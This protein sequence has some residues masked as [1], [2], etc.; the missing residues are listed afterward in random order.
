MSKR[1]KAI[2]SRGRAALGLLG[3][4]VAVSAR[5]QVSSLVTP[6]HPLTWPRTSAEVAAANRMPRRAVA[7][8]LGTTSTVPGT[9]TAGIGGFRFAYL[10]P[11]RVYLVVAEPTKAG[12]WLVTLSPVGAGKFRQ[13]LLNEFVNG[14]VATSLVDLQGNGVDEVVGR[15]PVNYRGAFTDPIYW[16][17]IY[18]FHGGKPEDVS[19]RYPEF[20]RDVAIPHLD[21]LERVFDWIRINVPRKLLQETLENLAL[22]LPTSNLLRL[23]SCS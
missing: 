21:Y 3:L 22:A 19:P 16:Y 4:C 13:T 15:K 5:G 20:Y 7:S 11:H 2:F 12:V 9:V 6:R 10:E 1:S 18:A 14:T 23:G 17:S 8:F